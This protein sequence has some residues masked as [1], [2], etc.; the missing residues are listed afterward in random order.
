[1]TLLAGLSFVIQL[2][3]AAHCIKTGRDRSWVYLI[4]LIPVMGSLLYVFT[5]LLPDVRSDPRARR[6]A[7]SLARAVDPHAELRRR[8]DELAASDT[9][10]NRLALADECMDAQLFP[11][12]QTLYESCVAR[13]ED[14][15]I[16]LKVA[17]AQFAQGQFGSARETLETLIADH[18]DFRS[19]EGHLLYARTLDEL[20][21]PA[22]VEEYEALLTAYPGEEP[23]VRFGMYLQRH[24]E[25]ERARELFSEAVTRARR[26]PSYYAK[27]QQK[28]LALARTQLQ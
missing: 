14:P 24:G 5:Q 10:S 19:T 23:R 8:Q 17:S 21:D 2:A 9:L 28:W 25:S 22:V 27:A 16:R 26:A 1:M 20:D 18:P 12:A 15:N 4:L 11:E 6:A 7:Q 3:L 13:D